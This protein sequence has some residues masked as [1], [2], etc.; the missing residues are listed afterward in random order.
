MIDLRLT[1]EYNLIR[2]VHVHK[3]LPDC[4]GQVYVSQIGASILKKDQ[5]ISIDQLPESSKLKVYCGHTVTFD[6]HYNK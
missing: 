6:D 5:E 3:H 4:L 1:P 2:V